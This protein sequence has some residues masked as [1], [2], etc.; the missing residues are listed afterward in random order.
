[1]KDIHLGVICSTDVVQVVPEHEEHQDFV[2]D[3]PNTT[4][5][6]R[7]TTNEDSVFSESGITDSGPHPG[8]GNLPKSPSEAKTEPD[9]D[10]DSLAD[11]NIS[12]KE[13][14]NI[15]DDMKTSEADLHEIEL[16]EDLRNKLS[17]LDTV[18]L[19]SPS[20]KA[21]DVE[22][23]RELERRLADICKRQEEAMLW[24]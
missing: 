16:P 13:Y 2:H 20:A 1:M 8:D 15:T 5:A 17:D 14:F 11:V 3:Q 6:Q 4:D 19:M 18:D 7:T 22:E 24:R 10:S 9:I 23:Q 12:A 21:L